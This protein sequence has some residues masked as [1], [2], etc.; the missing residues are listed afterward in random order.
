MDFCYSELFYIP[1]NPVRVKNTLYK[2]CPLLQLGMRIT[3]NTPGLPFTR[4]PALRVFWV[5]AVILSA[6][7]RAGNGCLE[8]KL[9]LSPVEKKMKRAGLVDVKTVDPDI[10]VDLRYST[11]NNFLGSDV[12]GEMEQCYLQPG[13]ARMLKKA[14]E[15]LRTRC[16]QCRL[17]VLDG[18]RPRRVQQKMWKAVMGTE[19]EQY[20]AN[21][22]RGSNHNYGAAVDVTIARV[23]SGRLKDHE[24]LDMGT[25]FDHMGPLAQPRYESR[26]AARGLL[27]PRQVRNRKLLREVMEAAGF[28]PILSEWWHFNAF[29][30]DEIRR[31]YTIIE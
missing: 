3:I 11:E 9:P 4:L 8:Q 1:N 20:V 16:P 28:R 12:Y 24:L 13:V 31:R 17:M 19:K 5:C 6:G 10:M 22:S 25:E 27:S 30:K 21:P 29:S 14:H 2:F 26:Y 15:I 7:C 23:Y 18:A